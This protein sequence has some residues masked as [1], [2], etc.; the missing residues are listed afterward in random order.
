[1]RLL[2][3]SHLLPYPPK[4]GV[5][6]R[7]F[8]LLR[9][10][11]R[12]HEVD[13]VALVQSSHQDS[14]EA[15]EDARR[16]LSSFC[17]SVDSFRI[18]SDLRPA[19]RWLLLARS[20]FSSRPYDANWLFNARLRHRLRNRDVDHDLI[21]VDTLGLCEYTE[22]IR[23]VPFVLNHHNV[24]SQMMEDRAAKE[25]NPLKRI[26]MRREA[27]KLE[28]FERQWAP[29]AGNNLL[30]SSLD[31]R[32]L[33]K[34]AE[35]VRTEVVRNG[36]DIDYFHPRTSTDEHD[37][38]LIFV[39][40]M[41]WWPN[42]DAVLWFIREIWPRLVEDVG[43]RKV[44][45]IGR[46]PPAELETVAKNSRISVPGFVNDIRPEVDRALAYVCPIRKG[47]GTRLKVLDALAMGK[48]L[49][50]TGFA[51]QGLGLEQE[52]HY[53][54]ADSPPEYVEQ[55]RRLE[56]QP[57]LRRRLAQNGRELVVRKYSWKVIGDDLDQAYSRALG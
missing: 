57:Y 11:A 47:G 31:E 16:Q 33:R 10:A 20:L 2:W 5:Q 37:G 29:R 3:L 27:R 12:R 4:G 46:D 6:Q 1:M 32:R 49:I 39:G 36:V 34:R 44:T 14:P 45:I 23:D 42:R 15:I 54:R 26:Y 8:H 48:P 18:R 30:V 41:S 24:E 13:V 19:G 9:E 56:T 22:L 35:D 21:H 51:V 38:S 52:V 7:S 53:L 28:K 43:S 25:N 17:V 55:V 50:A 40:G